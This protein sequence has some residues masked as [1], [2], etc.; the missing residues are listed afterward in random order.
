MR[1]RQSAMTQLVESEDAPFV[2]HAVMLALFIINTLVLFSNCSQL[3][4]ETSPHILASQAWTQVQ[5]TLALSAN[6]NAEMFFHLV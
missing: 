4:L 3:A 5:L 6:T 1:A 2:V